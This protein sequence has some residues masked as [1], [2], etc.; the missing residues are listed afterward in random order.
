MAKRD[1]LRLVSRKPESSVERKFVKPPK[2]KEIEY[3]KFYIFF[4]ILFSL[5]ATFIVVGHGDLFKKKLQRNDLGKTIQKNIKATRSYSFYPDQEIIQIETE[6]ATKNVLSVYSTTRNGWLDLWQKQIK[7]GF[8]ALKD[9]IFKN[10][11]EAARQRF[12]SLTGIELEKETF[13]TITNSIG[14]RRTRNIL[15]YLFSKILKDKI[16]T[17]DIGKLQQKH[18]RGIKILVY[19]RSGNKLSKPTSI[20]TG[21]NYEKIYDYRKIRTL[22]SSEIET[23]YS[24]GGKNSLE[25]DERNAIQALVL[26]LIRNYLGNQKDDFTLGLTPRPDI[27]SKKKK[28]IREKVKIEEK[29]IDKGDIILKKGETLTLY[30]IKLYNSMIP[31]FWIKLLWLFGYFA[32]I[33]SFFLI[34][35]WFSTLKF[36]GRRGTDKDFFVSGLLFLIFLALIRGSLFI[37]DGLIENP[38]PEIYPAIFPAAGSAL[39][40]K[41]LMGT[42]LSVFYSIGL[43][44]L[45][46]WALKLPVQFTLFYF[47]TGLV[48]AGSL[49]RI[50]HRYAVWKSGLMLTL[51]SI[52]LVAVFRLANGELLMMD[53]LW[54]CLAGAAGGIILSIIISALLPVVE[55]IG[56]YITDIKLLE[57]TNTDSVL[58]QELS[59]KAPGTYQ[60]SQQVAQIAYAGA[61]KV[62]ANAMLVKVAALYHDVGKIKKP[63]YFIE[64]QAGEN[65]H[66]KLK[67]SMSALVIRSHINGTREILEKSGIPKAV[68]DVASSH[69]GKTLLQYFYSKALE[70][71]GPEEAVSEEDYRYPGPPPQTREAGILMLADS[72]EAAVRSKIKGSVKSKQS[73]IKQFDVNTIIETVQFI[74][75]QKFTDGQLDSCELTLRDLSILADSF[76][77]TL[78]S[79]YHERIDYPD[80]EK[81]KPNGNRNT[82]S[83]HK[84]K[85]PDKNRKSSNNSKEDS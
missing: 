72:V 17:E 39:L 84:I 80:N 82:S 13:W 52:F 35:G 28:K 67:P 51:A 4:F 18:P 11:T 53:T 24:L 59:E 83:T 46:T 7:F 66:D 69:H 55:F 30:K 8:R 60:H 44:F 75:N 38:S 23:R 57:L 79:I 49:D 15:R 3:N 12:N 41:I 78:N 40:I 56:D 1:L 20:Q 9:P 61:K 74:I 42:R 33:S 43:S 19:P 32:L 48:A 16:L 71:T 5:V 26:A 29:K 68:I 62:G 36:G 45:G 58:L 76:I 63:K 47:I 25:S 14:L 65:P 85:V 37:I 70:T 10:K 50:E 6:K 81:N 77:K 64:N 27:T 2:K 34:I 31:D 22:I 21:P 54:Y 73:K